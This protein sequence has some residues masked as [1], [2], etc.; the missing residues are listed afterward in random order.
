M[1]LSM[2]GSESDG[3]GSSHVFLLP[4]KA[5]VGGGSWQLRLRQALTPIVIAVESGND[6]QR[7]VEDQSWKGIYD[8]SADQLCTLISSVM[9][10]TMP[11]MKEPRAT[12]MIPDDCRSRPYR[13][14]WGAEGGGSAGNWTLEGASR[15]PRP[16]AGCATGYHYKSMPR[17]GIHSIVRYYYACCCP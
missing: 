9:E 8:F 14:I 15:L 4:A 7:N 12:P 6:G 2:R 17:D 10:Y 16:I 3:S 11:Y 13:D 5:G 1:T